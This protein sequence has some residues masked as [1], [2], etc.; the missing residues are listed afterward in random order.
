MS[1]KL[2][3]RSLAVVC[4]TPEAAVAAAFLAERLGAE[5]HAH[6]LVKNCPEAANFGRIAER[7]GELWPQVRGLVVFAPT[8]VVVRS[9][10]PLL[11]H[12]TKDPGVV[13]VDALARWAIPLVGGHEGGANRLS[14]RVANL[15]GSE[16]IVTTAS[17]AVRDLVVGLGCRRGV[18][19]DEILAAV[20]A[21]LAGLGI[22]RTRVRCL[23]TAS[24]K[25]DEAGILEAAAAL[26]IPLQVVHELEIRSRRRLR[27]TAAAR[28]VGLVAVSQPAALSAGRRTQCLLKRFRHGRVMVA[29]AQ[30]CSGW[31]DSDPAMPGIAPRLP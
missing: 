29:I 14:E 3:K 31:W 24:P 11:E 30:E 17:E 4:L 16:P 12:K 25:R 20:E 28:H 1:E 10:A 5:L 26:E 19:G 7:L 2:A 18:P 8:G 13:V 21:A 6:T 9:I 23:A 27:R 15:L 22:P